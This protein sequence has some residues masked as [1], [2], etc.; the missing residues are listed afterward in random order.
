MIVIWLIENYFVKL[1][2]LINRL[3]DFIIHICY[4]MMLMSF[5]AVLFTSNV[6]LFVIILM[7]INN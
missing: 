6:K 5:A 7:Y 3:I 2:S 4:G 1:V